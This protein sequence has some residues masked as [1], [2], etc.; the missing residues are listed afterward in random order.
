MHYSPGSWEER[1]LFRRIHGR[2]RARAFPC[3]SKSFIAVFTNQRLVQLHIETSTASPCPRPAPILPN[4]NV[5][6]VTEETT[7][8]R[9]TI[10]HRSKSFS[11]L[12]IPC[13]LTS[14]HFV[15][16]LTRQNSNYIGAM[17][18]LSLTRR[19][20]CDIKDGKLKK[21]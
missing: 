16:F 2:P 14:E 4:W 1:P 8:S 21:N 3:P 12:E 11:K 17:H 18:K 20:V 9:P 6:D 15:H 13:R 5:T 10:N 7:S 19:L